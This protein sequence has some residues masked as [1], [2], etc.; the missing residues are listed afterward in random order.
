MMRAK[1]LLV[2]ITLCTVSLCPQAQTY[3]A[4]PIR[5]IVP[6]PPGGGGDF[7]ARMIGPEM[8]ASLGQPVVIENRGGAQGSLGAAVVAKAPPDG[9]TIV[10]AILGM[11]GM[12]PWIQKDAGFDP[13]R[14]FSHVTLTTTQPQLVTVNPRVP[15]RNL[16]ELAALAKRLPNQL[17]SASNSSTS[18]LT[19]ELFKLLSGTKITDVPYKG[20]GP[21]MIDVVGGHVDILYGSPPSSVPMV[22]AG[23]L[24]AIAVTGSTRIS[25]LPD[26]MT[27]KESGFADFVVDNWFSV[28]APANTPKDIVARLNKEITHALGVSAI[29]EKL[30]AQGLEPK[31]NTPEAMTAFVK[32]EYERWGKVVKAAG[33]KPE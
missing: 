28:A 4:K 14:D 9:H 6:F 15:V 11:F 7:V 18:Q 33:I 1:T 19:G 25:A 17:S 2:L 30:L 3:P 16:K 22:K 12:N 5:F 21:A 29:R 10:F 13:V 8:T 27:A 26:V 23:K 20:G 24:R 31:T 32:T